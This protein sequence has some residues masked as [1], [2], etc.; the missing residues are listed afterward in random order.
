MFECSCVYSADPRPKRARRVRA[1]RSGYTA[2]Y[3]M[4]V[5]VIYDWAP[6]PQELRAARA[7]HVYD[8]SPAV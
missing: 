6:C 2:S 1:G 4:L 7:V 8:D 3:D 5:Q